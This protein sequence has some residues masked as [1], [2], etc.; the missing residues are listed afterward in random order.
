MTNIMSIYTQIQYLRWY[1]VSGVKQKKKKKGHRN[2]CPMHVSI[3]MDDFRP[4]GKI[5]I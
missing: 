3:A 5:D 2:L 1:K 4:N